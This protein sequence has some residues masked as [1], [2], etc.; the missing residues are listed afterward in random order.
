[1]SLVWARYVSPVG[2]NEET[3]DLIHILADDYTQ[4]ILRIT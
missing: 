3:K 1:M 4:H 2:E